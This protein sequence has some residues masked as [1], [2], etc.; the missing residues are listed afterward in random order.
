MGSAPEVR[1]RIAELA[2]L[3][4]ERLVVVPGSLDGDPAQLAESDERYAADVLPALPGF[5]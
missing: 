1:E 4:I 5:G 3:G 2:A